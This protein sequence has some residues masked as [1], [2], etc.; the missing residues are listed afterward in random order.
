MIELR[1]AHQG[2]SAGFVRKRKPEKRD[3]GG[4]DHNGGMNTNSNCIGG[5]VLEGVVLRSEPGKPKKTVGKF[6]GFITK[7]ADVFRKHF[8]VD[9]FPGSL[10]VYVPDPQSLQND[11]DQRVC[12]PAFIIPRSELRCMPPYIGDGQ[13][14]ACKLT[15]TKTM[16]SVEC[17]IFRRVGSRVPKGIIEVVA[18]ESFAKIYGLRDGDTVTLTL[19]EGPG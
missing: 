12:R 14:W 18:R 2:A 5:P 13:A 1:S 16:E 6:S 3:G 7:N 4:R 8:G 9:L 19:F 15:S 10:N 11:L 17:W